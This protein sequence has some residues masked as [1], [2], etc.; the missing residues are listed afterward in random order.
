MTRLNLTLNLIGGIYQ[1]GALFSL[2]PDDA[3]KNEFNIRVGISFRSVEQACSNAE[4]EVGSASFEEIRERARALWQEKLRRIEIDVPGSPP[5]ITEMFYSSMYRSFL[6]PV[7]GRTARVRKS[8]TFFRL[9]NNATDESQG[10]FL[11]TESPYFDSL[12]CR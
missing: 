1:S 7:R 3:E 9:Q 12:Y 11:D 8:L 6:T 4:S 2:T 5:N 10:P